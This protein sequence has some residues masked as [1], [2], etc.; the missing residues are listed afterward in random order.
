MFQMFHKSMCLKIGALSLALISMV[1]MAGCK[2][3]DKTNGG[4]SSVNKATYS[5]TNDKPGFQMEAPKKGEEVAVLHTSKGDIFIRLFPDSAPKAVENFK[6]LINKKYYDGIS[7]HRV[8]NDFMIQGGDPTGTGRGGESIWGK[9]FEDE[10]N[11]NLLNLRGALS[12]ANAGP[13]TNGSQFFIVQAGAESFGSWDNYS[14]VSGYDTSLVPKEVKELYTK[15]GG[16][17]YLD[18]AY[19]TDG[20][21]HT[22]FGQVYQGMDVVDAIAELQSDNNG[23]PSEK[24]TINSAELIPY[25][26]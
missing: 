15:Y 24:V 13:N 14:R 18:G 9:D 8:I 25:E 5:R 7:F 11:A 17:C 1:A 22:V 19:K 3:D 6:G 21:G 12:M 2:E 20:T 4:T 26:G 16:T 10:F 23:T